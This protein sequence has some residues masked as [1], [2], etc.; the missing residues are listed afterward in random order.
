MVVHELKILPQY[1]DD[2]A[3]CRKTFELRKDDRDFKVGEVLIL[4]EYDQG[5]DEFTGRMTVRNIGYILRN[6]PEYGL[7]EGY[8]IL[9]LIHIGD[10]IL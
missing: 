8:C 3:K 1:Y 4:R 7:A 10:P 9:G 6:C 5:K 2:V